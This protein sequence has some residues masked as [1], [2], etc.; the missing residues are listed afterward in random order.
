MEGH[1]PKSRLAT[2]M[3]VIGIL[4]A[5]LGVYASGYFADSRLLFKDDVKYRMVGTK[6]QRTIYIPLAWLEAKATGLPVCLSCGDGKPR[7]Q[8]P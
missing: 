2:T 4:C 7:C 6:W 1:R 5:V 3:T 8:V